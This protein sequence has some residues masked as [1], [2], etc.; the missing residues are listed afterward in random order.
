MYEKGV[1]ITKK[2]SV[3]VAPIDSLIRLKEEY[4]KTKQLAEDAAVIEAGL[5][6]DVNQLYDNLASGV[7]TST[8]VSKGIAQK[9]KEL[10]QNANAL[11]SYRQSV[12]NMEKEIAELN[13]KISAVAASY[14]ISERDVIYAKDSLLAKRK[15]DLTGQRLTADKSKL[16]AEIERLG[17]EYNLASDA[18]AK[19][20]KKN[21]DKRE[22]A[23]RRVFELSEQKMKVKKE[24]ENLIEY[25]RNYPSMS[26]AAFYVSTFAEKPTDKADRAKK[27]RSYKEEIE[28]IKREYLAAV[29]DSLEKPDKEYAREKQRE[30]LRRLEEIER[31]IYAD[32]TF[33]RTRAIT[34]LYEND[35]S[36]SQRKERILRELEFYRNDLHAIDSKFAADEYRAKLL[37][38]AN[39]LSEEDL[40][41][42]DI[43]STIRYCVERARVNGEAAQS[44]W[45]K[46]T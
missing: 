24:L 36:Q 41:D 19:I 44:S 3:I 6:S 12:E 29:R 13:G 21:L 27:Q 26:A 20:G 23:G 18:F 25:E 46:R 42:G 37:R 43:S 16:Q 17:A 35:A 28:Q 2:Y 1:K 40:R 33:L 31:K 15:Y 4:E 38:F 45:N 9:N 22:E 7:M 8:L 5:K 14:S 11:S 10:E 32:K 30:L 39:T 34:A